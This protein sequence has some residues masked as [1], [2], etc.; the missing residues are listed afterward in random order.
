MI[1]TGVSYRR[2][3][4]P[5]LD[6]LIGMGVF[7]G[8][9]SSEAAALAGQPVVVVGG[10]NSAGQA[11]LQLARFA[12]HVTILVRGASLEAGMSDYLVKE[13]AATPNIEVRT[14]VRVVDGTGAYHL[15]SLRLEDVETGAQSDL[16][17]A[18]A[19]VMIGAKPHTS[20]LETLERDPE[21]Y[22]RTGG[23]IPGAA[24]DLARPPMLLE[25]SMPGVFAIGDVRSGAV[26]RVVSAVGD[27]GVGIG[28]VH[29]YL[30]ETFIA[31]AHATP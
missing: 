9:A 16:P 23:D 21:G 3:D 4:I 29:R 15:E 10:A 26:K 22:I 17:V 12:F 20:W 6:R 24:W 27:G 30:A 13:I 14:Q 1:A 11:A 8:A 25:T 7:Y 5:A 2:L 28:Q 19:F 18:G 31:A